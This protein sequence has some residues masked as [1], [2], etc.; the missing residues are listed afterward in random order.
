M[1]EMGDVRGVFVGYD[2]DDD[3]VV[4][5]KG[6]LLVYGCYMGGNI[7]Y[8][9]FINGVRVIELDENVNSF[10]MWICLKEGVV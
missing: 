1:K 6:I 8:N 2:Y 7:V 4:L 9:Y 3:Y 5:W 10:Y